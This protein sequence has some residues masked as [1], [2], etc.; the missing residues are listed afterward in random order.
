M[1]RE[2][3]ISGFAVLVAAAALL[4]LAVP[5][6]AAAAVITPNTTADQFNTDPS[7]CSLRE[8]VS[9]AN[10]NSNATAPGC[11]AGSG[12]DTIQLAPGTYELT[13]PIASDNVGSGDLEVTGPLTVEG[14]PGG[15]VTIDAKQTDRLFQAFGDLTID[16]ITLTGGFA[17]A[18]GPSIAA[19]GGA[20]AASSGPVVTLTDSA[21]VANRADG[22]GGG[23]NVPGDLTL[24]NVTVSDNVST[25]QGGGGINVSGAGSALTLDHVTVAGN[26]A[27]VNGTTSGGDFAGGFVISNMAAATVHNSI[28]AG[29]SES[30]TAENV[31]NCQSSG[32]ATITSGGG[33]VIGELGTCGFTPVMGQDEVDVVDP[34]L[35]PVGDYGG[36]TLTLALLVGSTA[37]D[38]GVATCQTVDQRGFTR[39]GQGSTCDAGAYEL[40]D[41]DADGDGILDTAD[42]CPAAVNADQADL[43]GDTQGDACDPDDDGDSVL[44]A[45]DNCPTVVNA[46]QT[47]NDGDG[48]GNAC[49][50]DDDNDAVLDAAD[51]CPTQAGPTSNGGCPAPVTQPGTTTVNPLCAPL[52]KKLK[53]AKK[54]GDKPK[55]RKFRRKLRRL[56]C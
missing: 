51:S 42:N 24:T 34:G 32:G 43:D 33:N 48:Q 47:N 37:I 40:L 6:S 1:G 50:P 20:I 15:P 7:L 46:D 30:S 19:T 27:V 28:I 36:P 35:A 8:A 26:R 21:V 41:D 2:K 16:G 3:G 10:T 38:H 52:R 55:V 23:I 31:P 9:S 45:A 39:A 11:L 49:D 14:L 29:N 22:S 5:G 4:L 17:D 56:G 53:A 12:A 13:I 25:E 54:R 18:P 44:D